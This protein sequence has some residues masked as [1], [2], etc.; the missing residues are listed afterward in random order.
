MSISDAGV[1]A[2][3]S[4]VSDPDNPYYRRYL[5]IETAPRIK[6]S[7]CEKTLNNYIELYYHTSANHQDKIKKLS[8]VRDIREISWNKPPSDPVTIGKFFGEAITS[9]HNQHVLLNLIGKTGMGKSNAAMYIGDEVSKYIA[10]KL[11]GDKV[12]YFNINNI[13]I[14]RL[15][16]IIPIIEDLNNKQYNIIVLDDIGAS[17][18]ARDFNKAINKNINKIFQTFRDTNTM[19]ILTMPDTTLIDVVAR[20]LAHYQIEIVEKRHNQGVSVGKL[21]QIIE[22]YRQGGKPHYHFVVGPDGTKYTRVIFKRAPAELV[23]QYEKKRKEIREVLMQES[24]DTIR[25]SEA[26]K[27]DEQKLSDLPPYQRIAPEVEDELRLNP[28]ISLRMLGEKLGVSKDTADKA[29]R[30]VLSTWQ[31]KMTGDF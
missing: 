26:K 9:V 11:K 31:N 21:V 4:I 12:N 10:Q 13:A 19:V 30:Y 28:N 14:M 2:L 27:P 1:T 5:E 18:S 25:S 8:P 16:S 29:K 15:D 22:Q 7:E 23:D 24:I 17:Y 6:C 3:Q 20:R